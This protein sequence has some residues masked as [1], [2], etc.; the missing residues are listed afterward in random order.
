MFIK[1]TLIAELSGSEYEGLLSKKMT[2]IS[3]SLKY[4]IGKGEWQVL[5][6]KGVHARKT[7]CSRNFFCIFQKKDGLIAYIWVNR[8]QTEEENEPSFQ[9]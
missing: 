9:R 2:R 4:S 8:F 1:E 7:V 5:C 6:V 3:R